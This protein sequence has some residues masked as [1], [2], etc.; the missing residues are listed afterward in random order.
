[1]VTQDVDIR[2]RT[3]SRLHRI[4]G[5]SRQDGSGV[6]EEVEGRAEVVLDAVWSSAVA[7]DPTF[8]DSTFVTITGYGA[9]QFE[10]ESDDIAIEALVEPAGGFTVYVHGADEETEECNPA[11]VAEVVGAIERGWGGARRAAGGV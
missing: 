8:R 4:A 10:W 1:M 7:A 2:L 3:L 6:A 9:V 11:E 5:E